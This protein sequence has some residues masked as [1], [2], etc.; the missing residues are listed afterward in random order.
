[1]VGT[2]SGRFDDLVAAAR[3]GKPFTPARVK[4]LIAVPTTAGTGS[5][6]TPWATIWDRDAGRKHSLHLPET[7]PEPRGDRSRADASLPASV[8]LQSGLDALSHALE[9]I[10]NV[11]ANPVSD[12][13]RGGRGARDPR[14][15]AAR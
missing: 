13:L 6:V 1:M 11:N 5:E 12:T 2:A 3:P 7:W 9:S 15:A 10:W 8:T 14:H 4:A